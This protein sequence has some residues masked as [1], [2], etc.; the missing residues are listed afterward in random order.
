M[1]ATSDGTRQFANRFKD[2]VAAGYFSEQQGLTMSSIGVGT[3]LGNAD[4]ETDENYRSAIR[5]AV[6]LGVNVI[7]SAINYRQQR[8]ERVIGQVIR[9][10]VAAGT[11]ARDE[12]I[13]AT[14][15]GYLAIDAATPA[16]AQKYFHERFVK[17]GI[18]ASADLVAGCHC[19]TPRYLEHELG[20]SLRNLGIECIDIFYIHNPE[21]QLSEVERDE[22]Y[23]RLR[24]AFR[25]LES[26]TKSGK[27]QMYGLA[28]WNAFRVPGGSQDFI[29]IEEVLKCA[30][31]AGGD[32]HHMRAVQFPYN[33]AMTEA[34]SRFNQSLGAESMPMLDLCRKTG[35]TAL[36]SASL[37]QGRLTRNLP[38]YLSKRLPGCETDAQ[39]A[40]QFVRS[41]PGIAAAL[42]GM[43]AIEHVKENLFVR[44][45]PP[46]RDVIPKMYD[47]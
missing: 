6:E 44:Q 2:S 35:L 45:V 9:D 7:D 27:I 22:F 33:L 40:I 13:I 31:D 34:Y 29:S 37:Y 32:S 12:L 38:E 28:T 30:R 17:P 23:D 15:A 10:L 4:A 24:V 3:Y 19:M 41:T 20:E 14:K 5:R 1:P 25:Y 11:M 39:R 42:I 21:T 36:A 18:A 8:S 26:A 43:A 16:D 47:A 46:A